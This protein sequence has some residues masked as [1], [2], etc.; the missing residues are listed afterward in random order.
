MSKKKICFVCQRYG[1]EVNGGAELQCRLF[2]EHLVPFY[3]VRVMTTCA[4]D[5]ITWKNEYPEGEEML[6]GVQVSRFRVERERDMAVFSQICLEALSGRPVSPETERAF[7]WEQGPVCRELVAYLWA[8]YTQF[9]AV[10]F[11]TYLYYTTAMALP[12][13][14]N[15]LFIP[16]AHDEPAIYLPVFEKVFRSP[17]GFLFNT[18]EERLFVQKKFGIEHIPWEICGIGISAPKEQTLP[19][20]RQSF[21]PKRPYLLYLG[22]IDESKNCGVLLEFF[23]RFLEESG[24][25]LDLVLAGKVNMPLEEQEHVRSLGFVSEEEKYALLAQARGLVLASEFESL[26]MVVLESM[27]MGRPV[28]VNGKCAVLRAHCQK[29]G[30]GLAFES[31]E[32]FAQG[33]AFLAQDSLEYGQMCGKAREYVKKHYSWPTIIEKMCGMIERVSP[34]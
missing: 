8:N 3:D 34:Q 19:D 17:R 5:Y 22:R 13:M 15:A 31:Y 14:P 32:Q 30:A 27:A 21:G 10:L 24:A 18:E 16:E 7:F 28:L 20:V 1:L 23:S 33:L 11:S 2:A 29:S 26:S 9:Q 12:G 25:Q 6:N 4:I